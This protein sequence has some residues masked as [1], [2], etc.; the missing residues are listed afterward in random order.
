MEV[1]IENLQ[2]TQHCVKLTGSL[3]KWIVISLRKKMCPSIFL[4]PLLHLWLHI[5]AVHATPRSVAF[6]I[7]KYTEKQKILQT[8]RLRAGMK[9]L[10]WRHRRLPLA[11]RF[12]P[13]ASLQK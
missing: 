5:V 12:L 3:V 1:D 2:F 8:L 9:A 10:F 11:L 6:R 4:L 13:F 7:K